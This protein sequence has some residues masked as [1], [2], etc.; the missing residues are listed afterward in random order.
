[1]EDVIIL[2]GN[3]HNTLGVVRAL[4]QAGLSQNIKLIVVNDSPDFVSKSKYIKKTNYRRIFDESGIMQVLNDFK[5]S[6]G[7]PVIICCGDSLSSYV[8]RHY[9]ELSKR[10]TLPN[11]KCK[12]GEITRLM[13]KEIQMQ[14][15]KQLGIDVPESLTFAKEEVHT[16]DWDTYPCII[17]PLD[18]IIGGKTDIHICKNREEL[19]KDI[20]G[21]TCTK[22]QVQKYINKD[23][24]Y[25]LIG[26]S[27]DGGNKIIIPGFTRLIRQP[28]NTNTGY[29]L[30]SHRSKLDIDYS[31]VEQY[32][33]RIGYSGLFSLEFLRGKDGKDYFMEIN[34]RND[35]NAYCVTVFGVN[36]PL[37]WYKHSTNK[38]YIIP[39]IRTENSIL[40]MPEL[41][42]VKNVRR[43]GIVKWIR[44][45]FNADCHANFKISDPLP[46]CYQLSGMLKGK[47]KRLF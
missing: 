33:K 35:G 25:Q 37:I 27:L 18:S 23:F 34:M 15:A 2:G 39:E 44:E 26:C 9:D 30:Y 36:L 14:Y 45:C 31:I 11:A 47:I 21:T 28:K 38:E 7:K 22:F 5:Y 12:Q 43:V 32:I 24:E 13:S 20:E 4:G 1:M 10:F 29:L 3:H 41:M 40:F 6:S 42:D 8:D 16:I 17:K 19:I 46:F